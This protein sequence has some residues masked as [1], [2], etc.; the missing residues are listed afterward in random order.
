ME[1]HRYIYLILFSVQ[2]V[3][4]SSQFCFKGLVFLFQVYHIKGHIRDLVGNAILYHEPR[5]RLTD[6]TLITRAEEGTL[7]I[8]LE[9]VIRTTN[10]R[11]NFVFQ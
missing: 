7:L 4:N 11:Q 6:L 9:Y 2:L 5:I 3:P 1:Y 8:E 10:S